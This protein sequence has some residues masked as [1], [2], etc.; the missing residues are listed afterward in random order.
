MILAT[1]LASLGEPPTP[2]ASP[3]KALLRF[4]VESGCRVQRLNAYSNRDTAVTVAPSRGGV[5]DMETTI[6]SAHTL[7]NAIRERR[8]TLGM[9]Q[10]QLADRAGA[11]RRFVIDLEQGHPHAQLGKVLNII[12]ALDLHLRVSPDAPHEQASPAGS[13]SAP[14]M[15]TVQ[16]PDSGSVTL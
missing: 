16:V 1:P 8:R 13:T 5:A 3:P 7:G 12:R 15:L 14:Y 6:G 4:S 2:L 11:G 10:A 9:T